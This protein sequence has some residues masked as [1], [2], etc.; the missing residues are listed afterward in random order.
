MRLISEEDVLRWVLHDD[1]DEEGDPLPSAFTLREH[2]SEAYLSCDR[3]VM[4]DA[5]TSLSHSR[6]PNETRIRQL[7]IGDIESFPTLAVYWRPSQSRRSHAGIE[8]PALLSTDGRNELAR[9]H[10]AEIGEWA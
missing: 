2:Q 4:C 9:L 8:G 7:N 5:A 6:R 3:R 10:L 1:I